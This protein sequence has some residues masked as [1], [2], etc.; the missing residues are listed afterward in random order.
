MRYLNEHLINISFWTAII[1]R[2]SFPFIG[3]QRPVEVKSGM[4][5][6][7]G[8]RKIV[9]Y[10]CRIEAKTSLECGDCKFISYPLPQFSCNICKSVASK[11]SEKEGKH[12]LVPPGGRDVVAYSMQIRSRRWM[13]LWAPSFLTSR[14]LFRRS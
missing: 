3:S 13:I 4:E 2:M 1:T 7:F 12:Q 11:L 8:F 10:N 14:H 6:H 5:K 9:L